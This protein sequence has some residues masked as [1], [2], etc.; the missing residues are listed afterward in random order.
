MLQFALNLSTVFTEYPLLE[1]FAHAKA[2]GFQTVEIQFP[3]ELSIRDIQQ[4]L[5]Q[6]QLKLCLI[7]VPAGD[8]MQGGNGLAAIPGL[9]SVFEQAVLQALDYAKALDIRR[10]NVLAGRKPH[11]VQ[12]DDCIETLCKNLQFACNLAAKFNIT[13]VFEVIN[14]I[15]MPD[16]VVQEMVLAEQIIHRVQ[17]PNLKIQYDCFHMAMMGHDICQ[18]YMQYRDLI[19]HVQFA[20][21]PNRHQPG[22]GQLDFQAFFDTLKSLAY[23]AYVAAEYIPQQHSADSFDWLSVHANS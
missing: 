6:Q 10:I 14:G 7:N 19:D 8:L 15:S 12:I 18:Q 3:Y 13:V 1:R 20:D 4:Q 23:S 5:Q 16:F 17:R 9:S 22:T 21:Y 2:Q 11:G